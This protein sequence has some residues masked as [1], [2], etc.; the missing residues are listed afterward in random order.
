[1]GK[2][3]PEDEALFRNLWEDEGERDTVLQGLQAIVRESCRVDPRTTFL[4]GQEERLKCVP[5]KT[6]RGSPCRRTYLV[7]PHKQPSKV[8][9]RYRVCSL[10]IE[11][12]GILRRGELLRYGF[13][14]AYYE[15]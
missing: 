12:P 4:I 3:D 10:P 13:E 7:L 6:P 14:D 8:R 9:N 1:M 2:E 5:T 11:S 15:P